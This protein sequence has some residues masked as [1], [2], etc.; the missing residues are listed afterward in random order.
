MDRQ[1]DNQLD[2][3]TNIGNNSCILMHY[4]VGVKKKSI[5]SNMNEKGIIQNTSLK[6]K[7]CIQSNMNKKGTSQNTFLKKSLKKLVGKY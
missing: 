7:R 2:G 1:T 4:M 3:Q 5:Q 6:G